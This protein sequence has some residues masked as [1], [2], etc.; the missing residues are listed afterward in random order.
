M[1][2]VTLR[3]GDL[4]FRLRSGVNVPALERRLVTAVKKGAGV[5]RLP[6]SGGGEVDAVVSSGL[7]VVVE[8]CDVAADGGLDSR[9]EPAVDWSADVPG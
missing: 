8:R 9:F 5:V 6:M 7:A 4:S 3:L 2:T 1:E